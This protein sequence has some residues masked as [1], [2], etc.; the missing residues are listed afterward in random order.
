MHCRRTAGLTRHPDRESE[1]EKNGRGGGDV[2][3]DD[4]AGDR[5]P[6]HKISSKIGET[7]GYRSS[8]YFMHFVLPVQYAV[9]C[10]AFPSETNL[11]PIFRRLSSFKRNKKSH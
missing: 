3:F 11:I 9:I 5:R 1:R 7:I 8:V 10:V 6:S 2:T 4:A